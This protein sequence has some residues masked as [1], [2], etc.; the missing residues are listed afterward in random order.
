MFIVRSLF[1]CMQRQ[2]QE[3]L[4]AGRPVAAVPPRV[5]TLRLGFDDDDSDS[6]SAS[7][8]TTAAGSGGGG[9]QLAVGHATREQEEEIASLMREVHSNALMNERGWFHLCLCLAYGCA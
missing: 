7:A 8:G 6:D 1:W 4:D 9:K 5:V 2:R 3:A